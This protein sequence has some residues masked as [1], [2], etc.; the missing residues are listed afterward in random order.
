MVE[1]ETCLK[2]KK[3]ISDDGGEYEDNRFKK[4]CFEHEIKIERT[5]S[6][7]P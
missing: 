1:N 3:L 6:G 4:F 5:V 2:I 7:T